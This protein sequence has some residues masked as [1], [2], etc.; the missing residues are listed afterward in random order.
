MNI[1]TNITLEDYT[2]FVKHVAR[3][4]SVTD[5]DRLVR[6]FIAVAFGLGI[7]FVVSLFNIS[8]KPTI[9]AAMVCGA[10]GGG[11][12][13]MV[14]VSSATRKQL[15]RMRPAEDGYVLGSQ[16]TSIEEP[17]IRQQSSRHQ[18]FFQWSLVRGIKITDQHIFVMVD[19]TAGI[20]LP[21]PAFSSDTEL[22]QFVSEL[23]RHSGKRRT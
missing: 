16:E 10:L 7:G 18:S 22:Q 23:E 2:A 13:L 12:L 6:M 21:K 5:G 15:R 17:G 14:A 9:L 11:F 8:W 3:S 20:I 1:K 19:R 4:V